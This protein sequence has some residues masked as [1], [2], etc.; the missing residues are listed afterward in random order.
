MILKVPEVTSGLY[1]VATPIGT[2]AD[3]SIRALETISKVDVILAEDTRNFRKICEIFDIKQGSRT[4]LSYN[5]ANGIRMRAKIL[6][7]LKSAKSVALVSD[8]GTP[9][10]ADPGYKLVAEAIKEGIS[11]TSVPG[12]SAF[13]NA[14]I[15]S[16]LPTD[17]FSFFGFVPS[18]D[19]M[20]L[21]FFSEIR[22]NEETLIF[23][24][25]AKRLKKTLLALEKVFSSSRQIA[26]C[27]ELTKKFEEVSRGTISKI[28]S[29]FSNIRGLKGEFVIVVRGAEKC[30]PSEAEIDVE[31]KS[32]KGKLNFKESVDFVTNKM[33][34][35]RRVVYSRALKLKGD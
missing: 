5:D 6:S 23:Y 32:L 2:A 35:N 22:D 14:L 31:L 12:P 11:V 28:V 18:K 19:S 15:V 13:L 26:V 10:I 8:A 29:D 7:F 34:A 3:M 4:L 1:I 33:R 16:G 9:L 17:R 24:D 25:V 30:I 20:R 27:R 21:K